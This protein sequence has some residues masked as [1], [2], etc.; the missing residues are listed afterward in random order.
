MALEACDATDEPAEA[1]ED[2]AD[3][4]E[5]V[6]EPIP[7]PTIPFVELALDVAEPLLEVSNKKVGLKA[8]AMCQVFSLDPL[9]VGAPER[10]YSGRNAA[11]QRSNRR[12]KD[13]ECRQ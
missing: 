12:R 10:R 1:R 8:Y 3:A 2:V 13:T 7:P 4:T 9:S 6:T 11:S 5:L